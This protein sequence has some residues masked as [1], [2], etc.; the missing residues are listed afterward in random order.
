MGDHL[1]HVLVG[2]EPA[3]DEDALV[4][5]TCVGEHVEE[6]VPR[7]LSGHV[8]DL[9]EREPVPVGVLRARLEAHPLPLALVDEAP[10]TVT[11]GA[12]PSSGV[13]IAQ[14]CERGLAAVGRD[15]RRQDPGELAEAVD[16][17]GRVRED[18][19]SLLARRRHP[20]DCPLPAAIR[21]PGVVPDVQV[22]D[23]GADP[24]GP[25]DGEELVDRLEEGRVAVSDVARVD[26]VVVARGRVQPREL[27]EARLPPGVEL[28]PRRHPERARVHRLAHEALHR[29][30][31]RLARRR[32]RD[33][34][35]EA[36]RVVPDEPGEVRR[37]PDVREEL[38]VLTE[39]RPGDDGAV[40]AERVQAARH[41]RARV[42]GHRRVAP[43]AVAD[44]LGR[45][46]LPDRALRG[47][48]REQREVAVA[49][50]VDEAGTDD[51][52][53][54]VD[55]ALGGRLRR[56]AADLDDPTVV[57]RD[58][59]EERWAPGAVGDPAATD[60][61]VEHARLT[62]CLWPLRR[63]AR[64]VGRGCRAGRPRGS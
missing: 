57:D 53:G 8:G 27:V 12:E 26:A 6:A 46:A 11:L 1:C 28:E 14:V 62:W 15:P 33:A 50:R 35:G 37:V 58:V 3:D 10:V 45:D 38:E 19:H 60:Q 2:E 23:L 36:D 40:V 49:V 64:D 52:A 30:E 22:R 5:V 25:G 39:R 59:A 41:V 16:E 43:A 47:R 29:G 54:R 56:K 42:V 20:L 24:S 17:R 9:R 7:I 63:A 13:G 34:R 48:V 51:L 44:D 21:R 31:L 55:H 61:D 4:G 32:A 18:V